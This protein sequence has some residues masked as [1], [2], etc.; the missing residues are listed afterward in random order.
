MYIKPEQ[1]GNTLLAPTVHVAYTVT[2][3]GILCS[4]MYMYNQFYLRYDWVAI[5]RIIEEAA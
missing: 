2:V 3:A 1:H 5:I 4:V